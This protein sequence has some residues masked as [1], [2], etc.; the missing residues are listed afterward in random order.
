MKD[1]PRLSSALIYPR[2][3]WKTDELIASPI[4]LKY[5][6]SIHHMPAKSFGNAALAEPSASA[7]K[8]ICREIFH[9]KLA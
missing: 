7:E 8:Q 3:L 9:L 6:D 2:T 4:R 5:G 1:G